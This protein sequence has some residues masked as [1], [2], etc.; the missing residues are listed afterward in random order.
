MMF[1]PMGYLLGG[2]VS[3]ARWMWLL[4]HI[5]G[6]VIIALT[7]PSRRRSTDQAQ[8]EYR[9]TRAEIMAEWPSCWLRIL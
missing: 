9:K 2:E 7:T 8:G 6:F 5:F 3:M 4:R 1:E